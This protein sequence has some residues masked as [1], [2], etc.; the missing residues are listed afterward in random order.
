MSQ[1]REKRNELTAWTMPGRCGQLSVRVKFWVM[2]SPR[3]GPA[4][5]GWSRPD[6]LHL[7]VDEWLGDDGGGDA[8]V[9][10]LD[11]DAGSDPCVAGSQ[12]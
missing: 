5:W 4:S 11:L 6:L 8:A 7:G 2:M 12:A 9:E 3:D 10:V 1:C